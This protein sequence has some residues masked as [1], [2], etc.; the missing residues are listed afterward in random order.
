M[1]LKPLMTA[2]PGQRRED[3]RHWHG[4]DE[5]MVEAGTQRLGPVLGAREPRYGDQHGRR[6]VGHA[7]DAPRDRTSVET[8]HFDVEQCGPGV[9]Q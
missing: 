3:Y 2:T 1:P 6:R 8:R 7:P 4:L 5:M 9:P